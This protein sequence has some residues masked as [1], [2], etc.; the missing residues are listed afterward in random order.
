MAGTLAQT[1]GCDHSR[2]K[3]NVDGQ[4]DLRAKAPRQ[5]QVHKIYGPKTR[6][7]KEERVFIVYKGFTY[8][9][10]KLNIL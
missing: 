7:L 5:K 6:T 1:T 9:E 10:G 2:K 4:G 8:I 3:N